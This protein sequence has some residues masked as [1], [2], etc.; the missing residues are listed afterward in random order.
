MTGPDGPHRA[1]G[2]DGGDFR[3]AGGGSDLARE[4]EER[5]VEQ[6]LALVGGT[7]LRPSRGRDIPGTPGTPGTPRASGA[8]GGD[9]SSGPN[10]SP[11]NDR[12]GSSGPTGNGPDRSASTDSASTDSAPVGG[13]PAGNG[14]SAGG[15]SGS[16][17]ATA[18]ASGSDQRPRPGRSSSEAPAPNAEPATPKAPPLSWDRARAVATRAG[19][20]GPPATI[21]LPLDRALGHVLAEP[22]GALTDLPSF[23]TS[24]M[25]GWAVAGP[26][27]WAYEAGA[28]LLAGRGP[29]TP[30]PDGTAVRI[31]TGARVPPD[32]T[33]VIR[34][35]HAHPDEAKGLLHARRSVVTGQ[36]IRPRG[37]ECRSGEQLVPAG[38]VVTPAVLGLA[39]AAGYDALPAVPRPRVDILVLGDELLAAGLPHDGLIRDAL[40]PMLG[41]WLRALG[42]EVAGPVRL[43][44]DAG[45]LRDA[46]ASSDADLIVT[47]G[48]TA[49]GPVDHVHPVLDALGAELLVD[50]VAVRPGHPMLLARLPAPGQMK[51]QPEGPYLVG[52]PGNP[53]AA[54]SGLLT[55]AEPLLAGVAGRPAQD[56]YRALVH[57]EVHGHPH[58]TRLVP[59]VHRAGRAGGRDHVAPLR[60]NGPAMLRGIAAA[61]GLAV[62]PPGGVRSG[63]EVEILDLPWAPATPWTEGCFT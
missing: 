5:A 53:L 56:A 12:R 47:T 55:L 2:S 62:V 9:L 28:G 50:G 52:L 14:P 21:R 32:T 59:V 11:G 26:G 42:A 20:T 39:A 22:L 41:P 16:A 46:L 27:P 60:Y 54:V 40:G 49:S 37:Q 13:S 30:L 45:A 51:G 44:D 6:A 18:Q 10:G 57:A 61:D 19:R 58:D 43:G 63:T 24:A 1:S 36:D 33:A 31:A 35:E 29:D 7:T 15:P 17:R 48:G 23:D 8:S 38:T 25:D 34:S 4:E 3:P